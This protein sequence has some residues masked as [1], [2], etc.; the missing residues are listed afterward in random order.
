MTM[1]GMAIWVPALLALLLLV[2]D[3]RKLLARWIPIDPENRVHTGALTLSM[4]I[5]ICSGLT[6]SIGMENL[7]LA[8][9]SL[10]FWEAMAFLRFQNLLLLMLSLLGVGWLI[11]RSG[12]EVLKRL[13]FTQ[14][15]PGAVFR[16]VVVGL[17]L[18]VVAAFADQL[19]SNVQWQYD[20]YVEL[21][22]EKWT[23]PL[24]TSPMGILSLGLAAIGEET[25]FRGALQPRFG[26]LLTSVL[27]T[28][29][30][31][32]YGLSVATL[33]VLLLGLCLGW[34]RQREGMVMCMV[35]HATYN[36]GS[37]VWSLYMGSLRK[38]RP[39]GSEETHAKRMR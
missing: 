36:I 6:L 28:L 4:L 35:I 32:H 13:G 1:L 38:N 5:V 22:T 31:F 39:G 16:G 17:V 19:A 14:P 7:S 18:T 15:S 37:G 27:F 33:V 24:L 34:V 3:V 21:L 30:H 2:I 25:L 26:L 23:G 10:D 12:Q 11:R 20:L 9:P 29:F 8:V